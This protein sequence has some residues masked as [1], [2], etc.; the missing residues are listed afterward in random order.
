MLVRRRRSQAVAL[1]ELDK[2]RLVLRHYRLHGHDH[3]D[4]FKKYLTQ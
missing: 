2:A 3:E 1:P 4:V